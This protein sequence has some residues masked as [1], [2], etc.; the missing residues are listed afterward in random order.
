MEELKCPLTDEWMKKLWYI[1]AMESHSAIKKNAFESVLMSW[2]N[3]EAIIQ[4]VVSQKE[5]YKYCIL[6]HTY[7]I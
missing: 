1:Y 4:N 5:K 3:L 6:T 7:G 2:T